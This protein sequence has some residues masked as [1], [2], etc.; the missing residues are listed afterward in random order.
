MGFC[1]TCVTARL[2]IINAVDAVQKRRQIARSL[3][4]GSTCH[5]HFAYS[6]FQSAGR[7]HTMTR[8]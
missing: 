8:R 1:S 3:R 2:V 5:A 6:G 4:R 7:G